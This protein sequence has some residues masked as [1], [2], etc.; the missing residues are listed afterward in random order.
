MH[1][2]GPGLSSRADAAIAGGENPTYTEMDLTD[3]LVGFGMPE[4]T[5][6][7]LHREVGAHG[8]LLLVNAGNVWMKLNRSWRKIGASCVPQWQPRFRT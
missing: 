5:I 3:T 2:Q 7:L 8:I 1:S 4:E 6:R